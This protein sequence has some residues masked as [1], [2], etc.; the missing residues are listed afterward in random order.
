[1]QAGHSA[2][3]I[4]QFKQALKINPGEANTHRDLGIALMRT[5]HTSE[6]IDQF[7]QASKIAP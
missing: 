7:D 2:E 1:M 3:A 4:E 6:A 5:G